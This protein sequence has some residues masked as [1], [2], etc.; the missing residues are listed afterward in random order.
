M[1]GATTTCYIPR[2]KRDVEVDMAPIY[3][4][5]INNQQTIKYHLKLK[6]VN[7]IITFQ[8]LILVLISNRTLQLILNTRWNKKEHKMRVALYQLGLSTQATIYT[9]YANIKY[10]CH[11]HYSV[12]QNIIIKQFTQPTNKHQKQ[13]TSSSSTSIV[14]NQYDYQKLP[15]CSEY[16]HQHK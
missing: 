14:N 9:T 3:T 10:G 5:C 12:T 4:F 16:V 13:Q 1:L 2:T 6:L 11:N 15:T 8:V 7:N